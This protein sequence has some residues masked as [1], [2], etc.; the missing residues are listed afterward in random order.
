MKPKLYC[1][2]VIVVLAILLFNIYHFIKVAPFGFL[3][4]LN[5]IAVVLVISG[6]IYLVRVIVPTYHRFLDQVSISQNF[7]ITPQN[8]FYALATTLAWKIESLQKKLKETT[9]IAIQE[10]RRADILFHALPDPVIIADETG[11]IL[12]VNLTLNSILKREDNDLKGQHINVLFFNKQFNGDIWE[13]EPIEFFGNGGVKIPML[14]SSTCLFDENQ[15]TFY[16][17]VAQD[18]RNLKKQFQQE[19]EQ[20][21]SQIQ[22][23]KLRS[24]GQLARGIAHEVNT[25]LGIITGQSQLLIINN[26][27]NSKLVNELTI[28]D[29]AIARISKLVDRVLVFSSMEATHFKP[30]K[31]SLSIRDIAALLRESIPSTVDIQ[32]ELLDT[33]PFINADANKFQQILIDLVN[34]A[35]ESIPD[36]GILTISLEQSPHPAHPDL[37]LLLKVTDNGMG[38][39]ESHL[40]RIFEPF[41][42]TKVQSENVRGL[43]L[44]LVYELVKSHG[45]EIDVKSVVN[46]GTTVSIWLP[47]VKFEEEPPKRKGPFSRKSLVENS[48]SP[49]QPLVEKRNEQLLVVEDEPYLAKIY[50]DYLDLQGFKVYVRLDGATALEFLNDQLPNLA[51]IF[52]DDNMPTMSGRYLVQQIRKNYPNTPIPIIISSGN[53]IT[54]ETLD[55]IGA[56]GFIKKPILE[57]TDLLQL[58]QRLLEK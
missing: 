24:L 15:N 43:G 8:P 44:S 10:K 36:S 22:S 40:S 17:F 54:Q 46:Q 41:F 49:K 3:L 42:S 52:T 14:I 31:P 19:Q 35:V 47:A 23:E 39:P 37:S 6:L 58:I 20:T 27:K 32:L 53:I 9:D 25:I 57:L 34:N 16:L 1:I 38:I 11:V 26:R 30:L 13:N 45:G 51:L 5:I 56:D 21:Q 48:I 50:R 2:P 28:I 55:L 12:D 4:L 7:E 33:C 18:I 29:D